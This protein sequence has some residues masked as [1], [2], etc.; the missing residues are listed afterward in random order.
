MNIKLKNTQIK[1]ISKLWNKLIL[2]IEFSTY[3]NTK[4][5]EKGIYLVFGAKNK[6]LSFEEVKSI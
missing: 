6:N 2:F 3:I 4:N 1:S 5:E